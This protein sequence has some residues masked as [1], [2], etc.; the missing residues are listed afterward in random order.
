[1]GSLQSFLGDISNGYPGQA[2]YIDQNGKCEQLN[3]FFI[4]SSK[5][6]QVERDKK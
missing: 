1:M 3:S 6:I 2:I 4:V 5:R